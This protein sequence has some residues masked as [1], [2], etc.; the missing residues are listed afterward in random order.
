MNNRFSDEVILAIINT[1]R[2]IALALIGLKRGN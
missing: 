2:D 1:A